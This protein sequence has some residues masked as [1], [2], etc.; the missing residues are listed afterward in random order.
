MVMQRSG[1]AMQVTQAMHSCQAVDTLMDGGT[2]V[3]V[4]LI[5]CRFRSTLAS[6]G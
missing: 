4:T 2:S 6:C 1:C 3:P 5:L